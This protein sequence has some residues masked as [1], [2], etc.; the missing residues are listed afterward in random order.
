[1]V[2]WV[3]PTFNQYL[4]KISF[5]FNKINSGVLWQYYLKF[6]SLMNDFGD[7]I[8][9]FNS[10]F[11]VSINLYIVQSNL[12]LKNILISNWNNTGCHDGLLSQL[13]DSLDL[14]ADDYGLFI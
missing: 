1:M 10:G 12:Q 9:K 13:Y 4:G 7:S 11:M 14:V 8:V 2:C 6:I 5:D 3:K